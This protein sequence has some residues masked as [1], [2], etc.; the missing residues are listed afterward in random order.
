MVRKIIERN[1]AHEAAVENPL[2][3]NQVYSI[4]EIEWLFGMFSYRFY[5]GH[6]F[7]LGP[8]LK[9]CEGRLQLLSFVRDPVA[10]A[11]SSYYYLRQR[12]GIRDDYAVKKYD[13]TELCGRIAKGLDEEGMP[14]FDSS[15]TQWLVGSND[16]SLDAV[17]A[18]VESGRLLLFPTEQLDLALVLLEHLFPSDFADCTYKRKVNTSRYGT[19]RDATAEASAALQLPWIDEDRE[20]HTLAKQA[21]AQV[22]KSVFSSEADKQKALAKFKARCGAA[23]RRDANGQL[24]TRFLRWTCGRLL[25]RLPR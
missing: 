23:Q 7:R 12:E 6:V 15:Q 8:A 3:S 18:A 10:K 16:A 17:A 20:L 21:T 14:A 11:A 2:L 5:S 19:T 4:A 25:D 22:A 9:A 1:F 24:L 13:F